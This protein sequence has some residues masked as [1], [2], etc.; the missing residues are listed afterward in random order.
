MSTEIP[1]E[2]RRFIGDYL[3]SIVQLELLLLLAADRNKAWTGQEA[4]KPLYIS[5]DAA[6][7][8]LELMRQQG[9]CAANADSPARYRFAPAQPEWEQ[10][11]QELALQYRNRRLTITDLI[12]AAPTGKFQRFADAFRFRKDK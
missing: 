2:L 4:A 5:A 10:L 1:D 11:V 8:F 6:T 3:G 7:G 12:Y 9:L